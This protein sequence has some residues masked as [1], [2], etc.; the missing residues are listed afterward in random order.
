MP[1]WYI[2]VCNARGHIK[3]DDAAL[4][5]DV[6]TIS[7]ATKLLLAGRVPYI[8]LDAAV[9]LILHE[10]LLTR[11]NLLETHS[12]ESERMNFHTE[13]CDVLLLEFTCQMALHECCLGDERLAVR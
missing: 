12:S 1:V 3:H 8:K 2:L 4:S 7:Q 5:V 11:R 6:I 9:V 13:S 10:Y